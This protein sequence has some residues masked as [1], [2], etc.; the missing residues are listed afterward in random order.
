MVF[1]GRRGGPARFVLATAAL[2]VVGLLSV[3]I[4]NLNHRLDNQERANQTSITASQAIVDV[5]DTLTEQLSQLTDLTVTARKA[6]D[7]TAALGP[8]LAELDAAIGPAAE[9]LSSSTSGAQLTNQQLNSIASILER[10]RGTVV[11]LVS[12]A[13]TFGS[14]GQELLTLV[15]GLVDDLNGSV[16]A[17]RTINQMLPLP[18]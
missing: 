13:Q 15:D 7:A 14:Q 2:V 8:L 16:A 10:I 17:A 4:F 9:L 6:L 1:F 3:V 12:S 18:G 5:N 11:P